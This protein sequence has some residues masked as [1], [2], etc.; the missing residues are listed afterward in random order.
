[1]SNYYVPLITKR[2]CIIQAFKKEASTSLLMI[3]IELKDILKKK[4]IDLRT[5]N[6]P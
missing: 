3:K 4:N 2:F 1:M 5:L 6:M